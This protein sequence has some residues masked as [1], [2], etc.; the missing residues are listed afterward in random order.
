M[1]FAQAFLLGVLQALTEFLPISSSGH[2]VLAP[3]LLGWEEQSLT[4]DVALHL[5]TALALLLYFFR[6]WTTLLGAALRDVA[7]ALSPPARG[8]A[9]GR[10]HERVTS[11]A[12]PGS[13]RSLPPATGSASLAP[14]SI[15]APGAPIA[16]PRGAAERP[17]ASPAP[18]SGAVFGA[19]ES[20]LFWLLVAA[21]VPAGVAGL[22]LESYVERSVR[23]PTLVAALLIVFGLVLLWAERRGKQARDLSDLTLRDALLIGVA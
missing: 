16:A 17:E 11:L 3:W 7:R 9:S 6:D 12:T 22:A 4:F 5:G 18:G 19:H 10:G 20:R 8:R 23:E 1:D 2:L 14:P 15:G 21:S 13:G